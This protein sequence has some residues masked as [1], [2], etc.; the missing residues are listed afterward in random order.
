MVWYRRADQ[1]L[2][3]S[4]AAKAKDGRNHRSNVSLPFLASKRVDIVDGTSSLVLSW[5]AQPVSPGLRG[6]EEEVDLDSGE[7]VVC[8]LVMKMM[9][10]RKGPRESSS[11]TIL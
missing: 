10:L 7:V 3:G 6:G 4:V 8:R 5:F 9:N 1:K 11:S 2:P